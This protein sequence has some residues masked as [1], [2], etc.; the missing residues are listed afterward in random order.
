MHLRQHRVTLRGKR[1]RLRPLT[2]EDWDLLLKWNNDPEVL[3]FAEGDEVSGFGCDIAEDNR[4][5]L[6]AF[7]KAGFRIDACVHQPPGSKVRCRYDLVLASAGL[8]TPR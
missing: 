3:Y 4:A 8:K 1:V 6:R 7:E 2:E 5:S